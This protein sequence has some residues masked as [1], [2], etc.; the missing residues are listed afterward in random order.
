MNIN[1]HYHFFCVPF[2]IPL[3]MVCHV[4]NYY[5]SLLK[6]YYYYYYYYYDYFPF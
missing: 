4:F 6:K 1:F 3:I 5:Y 2:Y